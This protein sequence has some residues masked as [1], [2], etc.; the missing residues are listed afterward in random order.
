[1]HFSKFLLSALAFLAVSSAA[2]ADVLT[3]EL[4]TSPA[5]PGLTAREADSNVA[6]TVT[7]VNGQTSTFPCE[8]NKC[9]TVIGLI[10]AGGLSLVSDCKSITVATGNAFTYYYGAGCDG[11][12][13]PNFL[14]AAAGTATITV[15]E[16]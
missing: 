13:A 16:P 11:D 8:T 6:V 5:H 10:F 12:E 7:A 1:M 14:L 3:G 15:E 4:A 9:Y 2:P